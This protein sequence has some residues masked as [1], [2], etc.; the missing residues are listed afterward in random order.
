MSKKVDKNEYVADKALDAMLEVSASD[1]GDK[2][3]ERLIEGY[4]GQKHEFSN[5]HKEKMQEFFERERKDKTKIRRKVYFKRIAV[6]F[7][8]VIAISNIAISNVSAWRVRFMNFI[9]ETTQHYTNFKF[10]DDNLNKDSYKFDDVTLRYIPKGFL[11][12][13]NKKTGNNI[14]IRFNKTDEYFDLRTKDIKGS[15]SIDTEDAYVK[16]LIIKGRKAFYSENDYINILV[17]NDGEIMYILTGNIEENE[18][19][20]IAE[21]IHIE[22]TF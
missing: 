6:S 15:L 12:E 14:T 10:N 5:G 21:N 18:L 17:W 1:I 3:V 22:N 4:D 16:E 7:I 19:I 8:A 13:N 9:T 2:I 11:L 20:K